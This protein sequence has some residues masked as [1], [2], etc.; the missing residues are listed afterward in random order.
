MRLKGWEQRLHKVTVAALMNPFVRGQND[1]CTFA[2]DVILAL[3]GVDHVSEFRGT[4]SDKRGA[5]K[6]LS[7]LDC[8]DVDDL[9]DR[10]LPNIEVSELQRGDIAM[11]EGED[12]KF[13]AVCTGYT[14]VAPTRIGLVHSPTQLALKAWRV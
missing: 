3:T 9:A 8:R 5:Y 12:G 14:C 6:V 11:F 13:L 1:C 4:Y 10:Y 7:E 2:A